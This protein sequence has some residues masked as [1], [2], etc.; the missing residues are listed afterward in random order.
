MLSNA[1]PHFNLHQEITSLT[2]GSSAITGPS[3]S[4]QS[5][6]YDCNLRLTEILVNLQTLSDN[7]PIN[8]LDGFISDDLYLV[9]RR[10]VVLITSFN[11]RDH[12]Q[13]CHST[14]KANFLAAL[15]YLYT[16]LRDFP[17]Q[18][19]LFDFFV[20]SLE[21][22]LF[23]PSYNENWK[24]D[25]YSILLWVLATGALAAEGRLARSR[26][27]KGLSSVFKKMGIVSCQEFVDTVRSIV[28][29]KRK[30]LQRQV[31]LRALWCECE[32]SMGH[33]ESLNS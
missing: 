19:P 8:A 10:L 4:S 2:T 26:F 25:S 31:A 20:A 21:K 18:A 13:C 9:E 22:A 27:V 17:V 3:L 14:N 32:V 6:F 30:E 15:I 1:N 11:D 33:Y 28:C 16:C 5:E 7:R 29:T 23:S 12:R 24:E